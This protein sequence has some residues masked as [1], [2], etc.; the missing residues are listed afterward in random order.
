MQLKETNMAKNKKLKK[1]FIDD[2][3]DLL[4]DNKDGTYTQKTGDDYI[5]AF[6]DY[7]KKKLN[8]KKSKNLDL[9]SSNDVKLCP[10]M[11]D[12]KFEGIKDFVYFGKISYKKLHINKDLTY[13][14][15]KYKSSFILIAL[16]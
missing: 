8:D 2:I 4:I 13:I 1:D 10:K 3:S 7:V 14:L 12:M 11:S 5:S 16:D 9:F 6:K 15:E